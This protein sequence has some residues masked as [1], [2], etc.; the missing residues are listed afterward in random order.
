VGIRH[1]RAVLDPVV[2]GRSLQAQ[3]EI[4]LSAQTTAFEFENALRYMPQ[5]VTAVLMTGSA[6]H[7]SMQLAV[8]RPVATAQKPPFA[9]TR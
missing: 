8:D 1:N 9:S 7:A 4:K 3:I 6:L 2:M 5:V